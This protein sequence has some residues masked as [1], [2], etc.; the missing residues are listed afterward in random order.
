MSERSQEFQHHDVRG[1]SSGPTSSCGSM[2]CANRIPAA[3]DGRFCRQASIETAGEQAARDLVTAND[4]QASPENRVEIY[5]SNKLSGGLVMVD[6]ETGRVRYYPQALQ[7]PREQAATELRRKL[8]A[9]QTAAATAAA[10]TEPPSAIDKIA[11]ELEALQV[12]PARFD[13]AR[14][15]G[16]A[17]SK[18]AA[19][20]LD[21]EDQDELN[22]GG[23]P[24]IT[25]MCHHGGARCD[26]VTPI[27]HLNRQ[28]VAGGRVKYL[29]DPCDAAMVIDGQ[30][31]SVCR[32]ACVGCRSMKLDRT[33]VERTSTDSRPSGRSTSA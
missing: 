24:L 25:C 26:H 27:S 8:E 23:G 32:C 14:E 16:L 13:A 11:S 20:V 6:K 29:C 15:A 3:C 19:E 2:A 22:R 28:L 33:V 10:T 5:Q 18:K 9:L 31:V 7:L 12:P 4:R 17:N 1:T 21:K 30:I